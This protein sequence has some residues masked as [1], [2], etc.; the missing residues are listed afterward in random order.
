VPLASL[1]SVIEKYC[2]QCLKYTI[3]DFCEC[4]I[5]QSPPHPQLGKGNL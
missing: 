4:D 5:M 1:M 2:L 3:L